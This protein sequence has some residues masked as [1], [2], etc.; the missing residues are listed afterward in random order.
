MSL[1]A[2]G[3]AGIAVFVLVALSDVLM[4][5]TL[6]SD[7]WLG[8]HRLPAQVAAGYFLGE[9]AI[10]FYVVVGWHVSRA[11]RPAGAWLARLVLGTTAYVTPMFAVWHAAFPLVGFVASDEAA[12]PG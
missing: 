5:T 10:P 2:S 6:P 4:L 11:V 7:W 8:A 3:M 12:A 9:L 1:R